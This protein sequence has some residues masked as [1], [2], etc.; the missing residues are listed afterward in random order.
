M[1]LVGEGVM[2][3]LSSSGCCLLL[4]DGEVDVASA[5]V[6]CNGSS[7]GGMAVWL[8]CGQRRPHLFPFQPLQY[9]V[10]TARHYLSVQEEERTVVSTRLD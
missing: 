1:L 3:P 6:A 7:A 4:R 10:G 9:S 2:D 8:E 5:A